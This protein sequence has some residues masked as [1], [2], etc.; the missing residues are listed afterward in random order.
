LAGVTLLIAGV[1]FVQDRLLTRAYAD[2][3]KVTIKGTIYAWEDGRSVKLNSVFVTV[4]RAKRTIVNRKE[5][6]SDFS[7]EVPKG[8]P[9]IIY[10]EKE[11]YSL[12]KA[13]CARCDAAVGLDVTL[14]P[15][16]TAQ[17][18]FGEKAKKIFRKVLP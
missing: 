13:L 17:K 6:R 11:T 9:V 2:E 14:L 15:E 1:A 7:V 5:V 16:K 8:D 10:S 3:E 12:G 4:I 18:M